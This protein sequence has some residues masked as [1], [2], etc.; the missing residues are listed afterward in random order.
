MCLSVDV[1]SSR[2]PFIGTAVDVLIPRMVYTT[3]HYTFLYD[4]QPALSS[5]GPVFTC[6]PGCLAGCFFFWDGVVPS[7]LAKQ[8]KLFNLTTAKEGSFFPARESTRCEFIS[9]VL[10]VGN[11]DKSPEAIYLKLLLISLFL[12]SQ[13]SFLIHRGG[14]IPRVLCTADVWLGSWCLCFFSD[15][16]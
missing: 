14:W 10:S 4:V 1:A 8:V 7:D 15:D 9:V 13:S 11:E 12:L 3:L 16:V 2:H 6:P 5:V